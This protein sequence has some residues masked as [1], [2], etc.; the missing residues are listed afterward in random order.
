MLRYPLKHLVTCWFQ[1]A[2]N[3]IL[4]SS[5]PLSHAFGFCAHPYAQGSEAVAFDLCSQVTD[6]ITFLM[7]T[8]SQQ[9]SSSAT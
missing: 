6:V 3:H 4:C 5:F 7:Q 9:L 2:Q 8:L 1:P